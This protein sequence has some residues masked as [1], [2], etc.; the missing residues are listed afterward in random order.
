MVFFLSQVFLIILNILLI[1]FSLDIKSKYVHNL[2]I[3]NIEL[4]VSLCLCLGS[5]FLR[6]LQL[7]VSF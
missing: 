7:H 6:L 1:D 5:L 2:H 4:D 3:W